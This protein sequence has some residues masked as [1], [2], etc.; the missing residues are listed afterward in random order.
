MRNDRL[1]TDTVYDRLSSQ[2]LSSANSNYHSATPGICNTQLL[3][4]QQQQQQ[5][6]FTT[7]G[8]VKTEHSY[9]LELLQGAVG[10]DGDSLPESPL[11]MTE[12]QTISIDMKK[13]FTQD[14]L[15]SIGTMQGFTLALFTA[16]QPWLK[17]SKRMA[18]RRVKMISGVDFIKA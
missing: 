7:T 10:S 12:G 14:P 13:Y 15:T 18:K 11:S 5:Q 3:Q 4:Q 2:Q 8:P 16:N 1:L 9:S 17:I 6:Q